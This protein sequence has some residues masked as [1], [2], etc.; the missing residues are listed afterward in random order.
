MQLHRS[1]TL[2]L[3][4]WCLHW[5][6]TY[7]HSRIISH[8]SCLFENAVLRKLRMWLHYGKF[9]GCQEEQWQEKS[10]GG[11]EMRGER[12]EEKRITS[13]C[14]SVL[15]LSFLGLQSHKWIYTNIA[16]PCSLTFIESQQPVDC[17]LL[18]AINLVSYQ[19]I[20]HHRDQGIDY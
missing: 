19:N 10:W 3:G 20:I 9:N 12:R 8:F 16:V 14:W 1:C 13:N 4:S 18:L 15:L 2:D 17:T 7:L 5:F 11:G 6:L